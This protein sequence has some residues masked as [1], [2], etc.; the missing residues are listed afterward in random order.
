MIHESFANQ[1]LESYI[2]GSGTPANVYIALLRTMPE[3]GDDG[4]DLDEP[5]AAGYQRLEVANT[6]DNFSE[7]ANGALTNVTTFE[8]PP[9][10]QDYG[11][12][13]GWAVCDAAS[14]GTLMFSFSSTQRFVREGQ[15]SMIIKNSANVRFRDV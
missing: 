12:V 6:R 1:V 11:L 7:A 4:G 5:T 2:L 3:F 10:P 13:R 14:A 9:A 8:F 15:K